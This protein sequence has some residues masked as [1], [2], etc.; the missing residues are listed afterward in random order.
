M[1]PHITEDGPSPYPV[2]IIRIVASTMV[3]TLLAVCFEN[4]KATNRPMQQRRRQKPWQ[5]VKI[6]S[7]VDS[8]LFIK[9]MKVEP[10]DEIVES[11]VDQ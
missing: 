9:D 3:M 8:D 1:N 11:V 5:V 6:I 4:S 10:I 7:I 2:K